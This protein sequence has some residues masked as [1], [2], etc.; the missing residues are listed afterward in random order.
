MTAALVNETAARTLWRGQSPIGRRL[1]TWM[2]STP[3]AEVIGVVADVKYE[4]IDG[5]TRPAIYYDVAQWGGRGSAM[6]ARIAG[7]AAS[8]VPAMRRVIAEADPT[9]AVHRVETGDQMM[10]RAAS[11]TRFVTMLLSSFGIGAALLAALGVYGV[12]AYLVSQRKREFGIRIAIGAMPSS[13]L[14]LVVKQ[15]VV[16]TAVGLVLGVAG[17]VAG[18]RVLSTFLYGVARADL[19]TYATIIVLVGAAGILAALIPARR[20]TLVDPVIALRE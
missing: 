5:P 16:L 12:L 2:D 4:T 11:S 10:I 14:G 20:A 18:T 6:V 1:S 7:D 9:I 19:L 15:G 13:V 3:E 8:A 17:A